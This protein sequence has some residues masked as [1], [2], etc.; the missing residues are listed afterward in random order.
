MRNGLFVAMSQKKKEKKKKKVDF[1]RKKGGES[2]DI[3]WR[4]VIQTLGPSDENSFAWQKSS[5][6]LATY[7]QVHHEANK[8]SFLG[9]RFKTLIIL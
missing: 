3:G 7:F 4:Q 9:M 2:W 5:N 1:C 6:A 8:L